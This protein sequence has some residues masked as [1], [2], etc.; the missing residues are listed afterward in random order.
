MI[1][2]LIMYIF[3]IYERIIDLL[4][5]MIYDHTHIMSE[6]KF[7]KLCQ[8]FSLLSDEKQDYVLGM[9]RALAF[10]ANKETPASGTEINPAEEEQ[11]S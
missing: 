10:A 8:D 11:N 5:T 6:E 7:K 2:F 1:F 9:V 4:L 3:F